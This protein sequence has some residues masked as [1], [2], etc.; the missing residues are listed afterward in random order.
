MHENGLVMSAP[1]LNCTTTFPSILES[2]RRK[3]PTRTTRIEIEQDSEPAH[4]SSN[5]S[6]ESDSDEHL[7]S[8]NSLPDWSSPGVPALFSELAKDETEIYLGDWDDELRCERLDDLCDVTVCN[9][10][11]R[12]QFDFEASSSNKTTR[13]FRSRLP[14]KAHPNKTKQQRSVATKVELESFYLESHRRQA[15]SVRSHWIIYCQLHCVIDVHDRFV[16]SFELA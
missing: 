1:N 4:Q 8:F 10:M 5:T 7:D 16:C 2:L 12:L 3:D 14:A 15:A 13:K 6:I 11:N 9:Y